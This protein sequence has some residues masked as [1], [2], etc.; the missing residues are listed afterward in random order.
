MKHTS[1]R[2]QQFCIIELLMCGKYSQTATCHIQHI[3]V[4]DTNFQKYIGQ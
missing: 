2:V 3:F 1:K 4:K